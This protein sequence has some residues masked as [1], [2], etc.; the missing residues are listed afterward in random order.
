MK[1]C[2]KDLCYQIDTIVIVLL[3]IFAVI[4]VCIIT[5]CIWNCYRQKNLRNKITGPLILNDNNIL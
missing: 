5:Y 1:K 2:K 3:F 4:I